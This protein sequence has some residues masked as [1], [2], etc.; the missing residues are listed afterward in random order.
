MNL[1][2]YTEEEK[3]KLEVSP[4]ID[5]VFLLLIYFLVTA[6]LIKKEGDISFMLPANVPADTMITLPVEIVIQI[7]T[8]G[9]VSADGLTF[10]AQ[11]KDLNGLVSHIKGARAVAL[12][13]TQ[14][15]KL[16]GRRQS[17]KPRR[18]WQGLIAY[19]G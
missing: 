1:T 9:T 2:K 10:A 8:D 12:S 3:V 7:A 18:F 15:P 16:N 13:Q 14:T 6:T 19:S 5:V 11:D 4:L 17:R